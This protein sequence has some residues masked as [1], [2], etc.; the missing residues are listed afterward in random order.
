M[1]TGGIAL[2][3]AQTPHRFKGLNI[4]GEIVFIFDIVLFLGICAGIM[5]RFIMF[6]RAFWSSLTHPTESLF[7]PT[8]W[9]AVA[10]IISNM[11]TYGVPRAGPWLIVAVRVCF[12]IYVGCTF[13]VAVGQYLFLFT[14][15]S[16]T[17]QSMTPAWI[18]PVF[19]VMLTGTLASTLGPSQPPE[20]GLPLLIAGIT[21]QGLGL[22]I[23]T[24]FY[25]I[26]LGRLMTE[27]LPEPNKRPGM[28]IAVSCYR[29][30]EKTDY[31]YG[32]VFLSNKYWHID[33]IT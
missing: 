20:Y 11:Q 13:L 32:C 5:A 19:P 6:P 33:A 31:T 30:T 28:F 24:F 22:L 25:S 12:W 29:R 1:S 10:N 3:L 27:G 7:F 18:L 26:F 9:I 17:L 8:F 14:G 23:A 21:F 15:K 16:F 2:V 4:L